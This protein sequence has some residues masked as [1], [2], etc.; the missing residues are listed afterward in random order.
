LRSTTP[1]VS[2]R[3]R[4]SSATTRQLT[5][6][7]P[8]NMLNHILPSWGV[9][10][11]CWTDHDSR[12]PH[13]SD[14][15]S[16]LPIRSSPKHLEG[17]D[18]RFDRP[19]LLQLLPHLVELLDGRLVVAL[20]LAIVQTLEHG[21]GLLEAVL[22]HQ[23]AG[24]VGQPGRSD[25]HEEG[26]GGL[27]SERETPGEGGVGAAGGDEVYA[28]ACCGN[29]RPWSVVGFQRWERRARLPIHEDSP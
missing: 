3:W 15:Q 14:D 9:S 6:R 12:Y 2:E 7:T 23:P 29:G 5:I 22:A 19:I 17:A 21:L 26:R 20:A 13:S 10:T 11:R 27:E 4:L 18:R 16:P 1:R 24:R 28:V 8:V 25:Q